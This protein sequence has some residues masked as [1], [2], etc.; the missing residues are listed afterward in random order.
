MRTSTSGRHALRKSRKPW[1]LAGSVTVAGATV[2]GTGVVNAAVSSHGPG[3]IHACVADDGGAVRI[4]GGEDCRAGERFLTWRKSGSQ[5]PRGPQGLQGAQG[6][7]GIPGQ[8][9]QP[10]Q[11]GLQGLPGDPGQQ[12]PP[13][14]PGATATNVNG[15]AVLAAIS[16]PLSEAGYQGINLGTEALAAGTYSVNVDLRTI[17]FWN[18]ATA[19]GCG[20][21]GQLAVVDGQTTTPVEGSQRVIDWVVGTFAAATQTQGAGSLN[22]TVTVPEGSEIV[23]QVLSSGDCQDTVDEPGGGDSVFINSDT[24]ARSVLTWVKL[25]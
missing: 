4:I 12:G 23:V 11:Q 1:V 7:Q 16:E 15:R 6:L 20:I 3:V 25:S 19:D 8:P 5:G 13:G 24:N 2:L 21:L 14:D 17:M 10:G 9:G 22:E 18:N